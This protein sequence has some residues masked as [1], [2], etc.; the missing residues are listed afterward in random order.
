MNKYLTT[1]IQSLPHEV[2]NNLKTKD[3]IFTTENNAEHAKNYIL[4]EKDV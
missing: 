1:I 3:K 4:I 2:S